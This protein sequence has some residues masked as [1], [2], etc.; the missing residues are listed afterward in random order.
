MTRISDLRQVS[1]PSL[2]DVTTVSDGSFTY[3]L[4]LGNLKSAI[5]PIATKLTNGTVRVGNG[6]AVDD[7]GLISVS[8]YSNYTL[9]P[10][11]LTTLGGIMVGDNLSIDANGKLNASLT[12][13]SATRGR[14]GIVK[15]GDGIDVTSDGT[16]SVTQVSST[17]SF[18]YTGITIGSNFSFS[19]EGIATPTISA[20]S[21][22]SINFLIDSDKSLKYISGGLSSGR[23]GANL[24][25]L[26]PDTAMT[27]GLSSYPWDSLYATNIYGNITGIVTKANTIL[28]NSNYIAASDIASV[29]TIPVRDTNGA[30]TASR[31]IGES[32]KATTLKVGNSYLSTDLQSNPNTIPV[33]DSSGQIAATRLVGIAN[34]SDNLKLNNN[35]V[36]ASI[37]T[38]NN[39]I[40]ARDQNGDITARQFIGVATTAKYADLAEKY[41]ADASYD[42]GTVVVFGGEYEITASKVLS[43]VSV[44]G[45]ISGHP[46]Y[47][48]NSE[49]T[50]LPV[51][52]KGKVPVNIIGTAEKGDLL[53]TSSI[54]GYAISVGKDKS[55]GVAIFAKCIEQKTNH[56]RGT[57]MAVII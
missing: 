35:Y 36:A 3:R 10:A 7:T 47:L 55:H 21:N 43:D 13:D 12:I 19:I 22:Q 38:A 53:V 54:P 34:N 39:T 14:Y 20:G 51:A 45:V 37:A 29:N 33:R 56:D 25:A 41:I 8:N 28:Y 40:A 11:S 44:A 15:I 48:M 42:V 46:A 24:P 2:T 16:I 31:F 23:G 26:V 27:L 5:V 32:D 52:L 49:S 9:P 18:D 1:T 30:I 4:T 17:T 50:G 6:L 57:I